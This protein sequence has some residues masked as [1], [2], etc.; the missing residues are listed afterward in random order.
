MPCPKAIHDILS[1]GCLLYAFVCYAAEP[2]TYHL[3]GTVSAL[4]WRMFEDTRR[5]PRKMDAITWMGMTVWEQGGDLAFVLFTG[6]SILPASLTLGDALTRG[7]EAISCTRIRQHR[8][9]ICPRTQ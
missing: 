2:A 7:Y 4:R 3:L 8:K 1:A 9:C 6:L 5:A